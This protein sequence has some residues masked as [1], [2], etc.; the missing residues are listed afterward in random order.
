MQEKVAFCQIGHADGALEWSTGLDFEKDGAQ[1]VSAAKELSLSERMPI[2]YS[3]VPDFLY[4]LAKTLSDYRFLG[5]D[6]TSE[7]LKR[8]HVSF[9]GNGHDTYK[10]LE[11]RMEDA[12]RHYE[13]V[14][15]GT[16]EGK[17]VD[18]ERVKIE[19]FASGLGAVESAI[20]KK[21][22]DPASLSYVGM[23]YGSSEYPN[24]IHV[25]SDPVQNT[26]YIAQP[27]KP[28]RPEGT[29]VRA[30]KTGRRMTEKL[31]SEIIGCYENA[32]TIRKDGG[33][34]IV[35]GGLR[36]LIEAAR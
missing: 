24:P 4:I 18:E 29:P 28:V 2:K 17:K 27:I 11:R 21:G 25:L 5:E 23:T 20:S 14:W 32:E 3:E 36:G 22:T 31:V 30:L 26:A 7:I 33:G 9:S 8:E 15:T 13:W 6:L 19:K 10:T 35:C 34:T 12:K 16:F 1:S